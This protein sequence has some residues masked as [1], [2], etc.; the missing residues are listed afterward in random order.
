MNDRVSFWRIMGYLEMRVRFGDSNCFK[1]PYH[2]WRIIKYLEMR[3]RIGNSNSFKDSNE[4]IDFNDFKDSERL[5][6]SG[7]CKRIRSSLHY[8]YN[9]GL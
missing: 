8:G 1:T 9:R 2:F 5:A 6:D 3:V 4:F 7:S